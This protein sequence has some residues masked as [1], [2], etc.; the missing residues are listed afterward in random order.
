MSFLY[1][2]NVMH[3]PISSIQLRNIFKL[4]NS[5]SSLTQIAFTNK[6]GVRKM[7]LQSWLRSLHANVELR[8]TGNKPFGMGGQT[9]LML[10]KYYGPLLPF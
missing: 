1:S 8:N 7:T 3:N 4:F 10:I 2:L 6:E 5:S 9:E